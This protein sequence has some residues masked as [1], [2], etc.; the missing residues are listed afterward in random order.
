MSHAVKVFL[1]TFGLFLG[2][3]LFLELGRRI[4]IR[5]SFSLDTHAMASPNIT[6]SDDI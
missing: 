5:R 4:G 2:M 1:F 3:L 6:L